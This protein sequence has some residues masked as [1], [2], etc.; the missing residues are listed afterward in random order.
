MGWLFVACSQKASKNKLNILHGSLDKGGI[1][2]TLE[3]G[4]GFQMTILRK[5]LEENDETTNQ[6][7]ER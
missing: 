3:T 2:V 1:I 6:E 4:C 7:M 5:D